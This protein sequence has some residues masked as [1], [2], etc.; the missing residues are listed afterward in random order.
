M[1]EH[2]TAAT[3]PKPQPP[4]KRRNEIGESTI[5]LNGIVTNE[6]YNDE[7]QGTRRIKIYD[8]MRLSDP[9]VRASLKMVKLPILSANWRIQPFSESAAH[10]EQAE[11]IKQQLF[12]NPTRTWQETL[13]NILLYL[14]YGVMPFE[15]IYDFLEDGRIGLRKLAV[16]HPRTITAWEMKNG[17]HG[18]Q[19]TTYRDTYEIPMD[20]LVIYV[21]EKEGDNWE[22]FS[23]LRPA[24]KP[25]FIKDKMELI[26]AMA[27]ERQGLGIPYGKTPKGAT[28]DD[29]QEL[30]IVLQNMRAN[31][32]GY[33]RHPEDFEVGW[34]DMKAGTIK[35][36]KDSI[37][38]HERNI[39]LNVLAAFMM[40]GQNNV[41]SFALSKD[42]S[43]F[44]LMALEYAAKY[45]A[46]NTNKNLISK[47]MFFNYDVPANE[48]PKLVYDS[49]GD[50]DLDKYTVAIQRAAQ[51][52]V[53]TPD[54]SIERHLRDL[55]DLPESDGEK[56]E[57]TDA[58]F[59][60]KPLQVAINKLITSSRGEE[61]VPEEVRK[62]YKKVSNF[63]AETE[64][65][66]LSMQKKGQK[67]TRED[68]A[69][70]HL[71]RYDSFRSLLDEIA[72]LQFEYVQPAIEAPEP[73]N[74]NGDTPE[75]E[76]TDQRFL[77]LFAS[78]E[79]QLETLKS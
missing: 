19:Q 78:V 44:F 7:L 48:N 64:K 49:I 70:E 5:L 69:K 77:D 1:A 16:R 4:S 33:V 47:L 39:M 25:F 50:V 9:V 71:K 46:T 40:L 22:G 35:N 41:G 60:V 51:V 52:G 72:E 58:S 61:G 56:V 31:E 11:F 14:D 20:K 6:E 73:E 3:P 13:T 37:E 66:Y 63:I 32:K 30:D 17:E 15:I 62:L 65:D 26:E 74:D 23:I 28:E 68:M 36:P 34:T 59:I 57:I 43:G 55:F 24:Y 42:H 75:V 53:L 10:K 2:A 29:K 38:R 21:N 45:I 18:I 54:S 12:E 79:E 8:Q 27:M 76:A 67:L